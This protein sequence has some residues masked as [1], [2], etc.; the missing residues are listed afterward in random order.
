MLLACHLLLLTQ[1][2]PTREVLLPAISTSPGPCTV[3]SY[4]P[5]QPHP[6]SISD[7]LLSYLLS[8]SPSMESLPSAWHLVRAR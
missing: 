6:L 3:L 1:M 4:F 7:L 2:S 8:F 5:R